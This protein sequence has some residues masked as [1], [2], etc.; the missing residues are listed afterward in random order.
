MKNVAILGATGS[1]GQNSLKVIE[2]LSQRFFPFCITAHKNIFLLEQQIKK[3][4]PEIV[5]ITDKESA[6]KFKPPKEIKFLKGNKGLLEIARNKEIDIIINALSGVESIYPMLTAIKNKKRIC[7]ANKEVIVSYGSIINEELEKQ[8]EAELLPVDSEHSA[9]HQCI[10]TSHHYVKRIILTASGGPFRDREI[11]STITPDEALKHPT[12]DM[13]K[14]ITV[15]SATL[16]NKGLEIIEAS[17]LFNIPPSKIEVL[18]HPQSIIHS[19]VE[20]IDGSILAQ[21]S[22]PDMKLPIQYALTYPE[23]LPSLVKTLDLTE[24]GTLEFSKPDFNKFHALKLAYKALEIGSTLPAVL[25][26]ANETAVSLF[27]ENKISLIEITNIV[28]SVMNKHKSIP[29]PKIE[30]IQQA[31]KWAREEAIKITK[32]E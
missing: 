16:M 24:I 2:S 29:T 15:D 14:K 12:W 17:R 6:D 30:N 19:M 18:I 3:Y 11:L 22:T 10:N 26:A 8:P 4:N 27:L 28:E 1:I 32:S 31:E 9:I 13:G 21:L 23:K 20:F 5:C 25:N 7:I